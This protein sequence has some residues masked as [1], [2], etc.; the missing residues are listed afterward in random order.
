MKRSQRQV[1]WWVVVSLLS[2]ACLL[3]IKTP[4]VEAHPGRTDSSGGHTCRTNCS[5]WGL[6]FG[7]YHTHGGTTT[8]TPTP[9]PDI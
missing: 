3:L 8:P 9:T 7:Q 4:S 6:R 1:Y 5:K 2:I